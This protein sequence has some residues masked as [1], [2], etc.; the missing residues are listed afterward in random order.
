MKAAGS[1]VGQVRR[2][3]ARLRAKCR[4]CGTEL[5]TDPDD[6]G[7]VVE[8]T[9]FNGKSLYKTGYYAFKMKCVRC[10][11]PVEFGTSTPLN[12]TKL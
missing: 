12:A 8:G 4:Y 5:T 2:V 3:G 7:R 9:R 6:K 11:R 10:G 1:F